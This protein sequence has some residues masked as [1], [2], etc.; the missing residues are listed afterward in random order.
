MRASEAMFV[1]TPDRHPFD[2]PEFPL[3]G[4]IAVTTIP[5]SPENRLHP[6]SYGASNL[7]WREASEAERRQKAQALVS[8][9]IH[10]DNIPEDR[11]RDAFQQVEEYASFPF[12]T[13][14]VEKEEDDD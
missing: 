11:V 5:E 7:D 12:H 10:D 2:G 6:M 13:N 4:T 8:Q 9:L 14:P 1:W 3:K